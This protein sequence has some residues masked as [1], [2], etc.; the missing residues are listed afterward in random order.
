MTPAELR[1]SLFAR[2]HERPAREDHT[3]VCLHCGSVEESSCSACDEAQAFA[4]PP[5]F[6][7]ALADLASELET[8]R[9]DVLRGL[10][11]VGLASIERGGHAAQTRA[12]VFLRHLE[13][14]EEGG[15]SDSSSGLLGLVGTDTAEG[16]G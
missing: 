6:L 2:R 3:H 9:E 8:T 13:E 5:G 16:A 14:A 7:H 4:F 12:V 11:A 1:E 15:A 10:L